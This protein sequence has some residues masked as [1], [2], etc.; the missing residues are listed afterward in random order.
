MAALQIALFLVVVTERLTEAIV[1]P[2]KK[3]FPALDFWWMVYVSWVVGGALVFLAGVNLFEGVFENVL[4]GQILSAVVGGG[5]ANL[6]HDL[7][8]KLGSQAIPQ[9]TYSEIK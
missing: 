1:A 8:D 4:I 3:R 6:L 2:V 5:G 9:K 7:F